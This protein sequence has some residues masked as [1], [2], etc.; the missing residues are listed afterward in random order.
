MCPHRCLCLA[1]VV[2]WSRYRISSADFLA[3]V[4]AVPSWNGSL[5]LGLNFRNGDDP[6]G[7]CLRVAVEGGGV[8][9]GGAACCGHQLF[10]CVRLGVA[11]V[12]ELVGDRRV[13]N[14]TEVGQGCKVAG[15][16]WLSLVV[17]WGGLCVFVWWYRRSS[18]CLGFGVEGMKGW[19]WLVALV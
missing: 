19:G 3:Y 11:V 18:G 16:G 5:V 8:G 2:R 9:R 15:L 1:L 14:W 6:V 10:F 7:A 17:V 13:W 4:T 12:I